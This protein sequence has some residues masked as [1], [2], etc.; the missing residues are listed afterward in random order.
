[1]GYIAIRYW[2]AGSNLLELKAF[3]VASCRS[4]MLGSNPLMAPAPPLRRTGR[5]EDQQG[6][7]WP[8]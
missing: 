3:P 7:D 5:R 6:L 4:K 2:I 1:M 8:R